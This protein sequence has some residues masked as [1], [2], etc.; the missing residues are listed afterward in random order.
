MNGLTRFPL[1]LS[2]PGIGD[3]RKPCSTDEDDDI[4]PS[5]MA[6]Y[7]P[8]ELLAAAN[9]AA[10]NIGDNIK[11]P[12][13][14]LNKGDSANVNRELTYISEVVSHM[15]LALSESERSVDTSKARVVI[16]QSCLEEEKTRSSISGIKAE[17]VAAAIAATAN[18]T[19]SGKKQTYAEK[20]MAQTGPVVAVYPS[21]KGAAL[22]TAD[23]TKSA[24]KT[25]VAP[26]ALNIK[27][28]KVRRLAGA[29][30]LVQTKTREDLEKLKLA[31][32]PTL[33]ASEPK[34]RQ[35]LVALRNLEGKASISQP[36]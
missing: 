35:P 16:L 4:Q 21:E 13:A 11:H 5:G 30:V 19:I 28:D 20:L 25:S 24:L 26:A 6:H 34:R 23:D 36:F 18:S 29:G 14:K 12:T 32:P 27:V 8:R 2:T 15:A 31:I 10:R 33:R 22:K 9:K 17:Q 3:F 7:S 1:F